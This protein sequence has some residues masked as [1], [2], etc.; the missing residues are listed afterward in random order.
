MS[1]SKHEDRGGVFEDEGE[2]P[3]APPRHTSMSV[4]VDAVDAE[5]HGLTFS[6]DS[7]YPVETP[8]DTPMPGP[9]PTFP[10]TPFIPDE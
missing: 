5:I 7:I 10:P 4:A 8:A 9:S 1:G 3:S 2:T 6:S